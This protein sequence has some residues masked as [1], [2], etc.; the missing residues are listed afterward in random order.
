MHQSVNSKGVLHQLQAL[1]FNGDG[2]FLNDFAQLAVP[3]GTRFATFGAEAGHL[4][5]AELGVGLLA[6]KASLLG[7]HAD[8]TKLPHAL[9]CEFTQRIQ[10]MLLVLQTDQE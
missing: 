5:L 8:S 3:W 1:V 2:R 10:F 7:Q 6:N 4:A 9:E